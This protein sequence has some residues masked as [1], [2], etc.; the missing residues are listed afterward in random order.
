MSAGAAWANP[1][2]DVEPGDW[3]YSA[4]EYVNTER[5]FNG[6]AEDRFS[7]GSPMTRGMF[8]TVLGKFAQADTEP[9][10]E[11]AFQD[12][13]AGAYYA[14]YVGWAAEKGVVNGV[15]ATEFAPG[16][17]ITREQ[18]ATMLYNYAQE[19]GC[20]VSSNPEALR[21]FPDGGSVS[22]YAQEPMA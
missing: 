20:D 7:P 11:P 16:R 10:G 1:F 21:K 3:F 13:P 4:V 14:P 12:V 5:L 8:V 17:D 2:A 15:S 6:T 9:Y 22:A 18:M 19:A